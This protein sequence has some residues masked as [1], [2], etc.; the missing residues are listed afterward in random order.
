MPVLTKLRIGLAR[1]ARVTTASHAL[2]GGA[3]G[4]GRA[5]DAAVAVR[6]PGDPVL[7]RRAAARLPAVVRVG[8]ARRTQS[9]LF[10]RYSFYNHIL[11]NERGY[12]SYYGWQSPTFG[13][14]A[15]TR[16]VRIS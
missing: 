15:F 12:C 16:L 5:Q 1:V 3:A 2:A 10:D 8:M 11:K 6:L 7:P 4:V 14:M 9:S 13:W